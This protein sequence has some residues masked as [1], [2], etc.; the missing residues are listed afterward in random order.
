M[1]FLEVLYCTM[2][3]SSWMLGAEYI[4]VEFH[5]ISATDLFEDSLDFH[6]IIYVIQLLSSNVIVNIRQH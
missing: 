1:L 3:T 4:N 2:V 6:I 5:S